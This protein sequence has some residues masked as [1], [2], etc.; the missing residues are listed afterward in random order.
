MEK[1]ACTFIMI[2]I[3]WSKINGSFRYL[4]YQCR[5]WTTYELLKH[6]T[7]STPTHSSIDCSDSTKI[8]CFRWTF[9]NSQCF[10]WNRILSPWILLTPHCLFPPVWTPGPVCIPG[11]QWSVA[12]QGHWWD[13]Q[14]GRSRGRLGCAAA[15]AWP[16]TASASPRWPAWTLPWTRLV[17]DVWHYY[18]LLVMCNYL[19]VSA[20]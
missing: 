18:G 7:T 4:I 15:G 11:K 9:Q 14:T 20:G 5:Y 13:L 3:K 16:H 2:N 1:L 12:A 17:S 19:N 8:C 10:P 6:L